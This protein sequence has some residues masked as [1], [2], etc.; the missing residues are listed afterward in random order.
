M[1]SCCE[2]FHAHG[3]Q[4][5]PMEE[6]LSLLF[7]LLHLCLLDFDAAFEGEDNEECRGRCQG[8][9]AEGG[10]APVVVVAVF[11][12]GDSLFVAQLVVD[13]VFGQLDVGGCQAVGFAELAEALEGL[14]V[15]VLCLVAGYFYFE[16]C[17]EQAF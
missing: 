6:V 12:L 11:E 5:L 17:F 8:E 4:F 16:A 9:Q 7:Y 10:D 2:L 15:V 13:E 3:F 1:F 14:F